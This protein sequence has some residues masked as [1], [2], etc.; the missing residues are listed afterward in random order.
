MS[1]T[2]ANV[3]AAF[4]T[5]KE[6]CITAGI[7]PRFLELHRESE[8]YYVPESEWYYV[9]E[10]VPGDSVLQMTPFGSARGF[11][12]GC[13]GTADTAVATLRSWAKMVRVET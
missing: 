13:I 11:N 3:K 12:G 7:D 9:L 2:N 6:A 1:C 4:K 8:W 10:R 5:L